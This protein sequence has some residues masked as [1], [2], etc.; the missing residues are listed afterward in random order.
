MPPSGW[1]ID[2]L[3]FSGWTLA[4]LISQEVSVDGILI[5]GLTGTDSMSLKCQTF[6]FPLDE[7]NKG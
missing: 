1:V 3:S 7:G 2:C 4:K 5:P 6:T